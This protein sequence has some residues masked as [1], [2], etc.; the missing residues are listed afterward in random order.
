M[1]IDAEME[2]RLA[3][4]IQSGIVK[5]WAW[6]LV[7]L[8]GYGRFHFPFYT[9]RPGVH[10]K[11]GRRALRLGERYD[12]GPEPDS[13]LIIQV[14]LICRYHQCE[15]LI[16][17]IAA[18][19]EAKSSPW[20][21]R[22]FYGGDCNEPEDMTLLDVKARDAMFAELVKQFDVGD[23]F[24]PQ[25]PHPKCGFCEQPMFRS[26][27]GHG[28]FGSLCTVCDEH[29]ITDRDGK[30]VSRAFGDWPE[31]HTNETT[32]AIIAAKKLT[33]EYPGRRVSDDKVTIGVEVLK[34]LLWAAERSR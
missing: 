12:E 25:N 1:G 33:D 18:W 15:S 26:L 5:R 29:V 22:V 6:E 23:D 24:A 9:H 10:E 7:R 11:E 8:A 19:L 21:S 4:P 13:G 27:S 14:S 2:V 20:G 28:V 16:M 34:S 31:P 32:R 30:F 17:F 3:K